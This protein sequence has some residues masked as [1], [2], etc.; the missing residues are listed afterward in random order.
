MRTNLTIIRKSW[1]ADRRVEVRGWDL[2]LLMYMHV[3]S[4]A[5][6]RRSLDRR[7]AADWRKWVCL[8]PRFSRTWASL[9]FRPLAR[10]ECLPVV[11]AGEASHF[12]P[13]RGVNGIQRIPPA[14]VSTFQAAKCFWY[15]LVSTHIGS[16]TYQMYVLLAVGD[17]DVDVNAAVDVNNVIYLW[18]CN[19]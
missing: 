1:I 11:P 19:G 12:D 13:R 10:A 9:S 15:S 18:A 3:L 5:W 7:P 6:I 14:D 16:F 4:V 8:K 2:Q 17:V